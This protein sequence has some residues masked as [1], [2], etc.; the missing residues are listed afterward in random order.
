MFDNL[1]NYVG[2]C[3]LHLQVWYP[4]G[5]VKVAASLNAELNDDV[6]EKIVKVPLV[7]LPNNQL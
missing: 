5:G 3:S 4:K 1:F 2:F 6:F 7:C